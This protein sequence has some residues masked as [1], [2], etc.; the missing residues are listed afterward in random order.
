M[1]ALTDLTTPPY[2]TLFKASNP[3]TQEEKVFE[4]SEDALVW[5]L[6]H[7]NWILKKRETIY[8]TFPLEQIIA[9]DCW[10]KVG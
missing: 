2:P 5:A 8:W 1:K 4:N 10:V 6:E 7:R 3:S 9:K